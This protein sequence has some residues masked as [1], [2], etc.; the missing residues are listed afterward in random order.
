MATGGTSVR[1]AFDAW[2]RPP[3]DANLRL[4]ILA[5]IAI[6]L[7]PMQAHRLPTLGDAGSQF[8]LG[9]LAAK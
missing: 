6:R 9:A 8:Q 2:T 1:W 5:L 3:L 4:P 7:A